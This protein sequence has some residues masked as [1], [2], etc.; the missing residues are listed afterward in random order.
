M[1]IKVKP[2]GEVAEKW[3]RVTPGR[4]GDYQKG[5]EAAGGDWASNAAA[6]TGNWRAA[7][8]A[9]AAE[10]ALRSGISRA[11]AGKYVRGIKEKGAARYG[12]GVQAARPDFESAMGPVMATIAG[13]DLPARQ[14]RGSAANMARSSKVADALAK[15]RA[16]RSAAGR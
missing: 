9:P 10:A 16:S 5:A 14:P 1:A 13:V 4:A 12:P 11:G 6:G 15:A 3:A 8:T 7:V 2:V